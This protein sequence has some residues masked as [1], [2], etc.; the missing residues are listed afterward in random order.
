VGDKGHDFRKSLVAIVD[1]PEDNVNFDCPWGFQWMDGEKPP[2]EKAEAPAPV[3]A[4]VPLEGAPSPQPLQ[5]GKPGGCGCGKRS[6]QGMVTAPD[7]TQSPTTIRLPNPEFMANVPRSQCPDCT[8][9][10]IAQAII[11]LQE[12]IDGHPEHRMLAIGHLAEAVAEIRQLLPDI[13][14]K[15]EDTFHQMM[16]EPE[17]MP[18]LMPFIM[19]ISQKVAEALAAQGPTGV[20]GT[21]VS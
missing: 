1:L 18:D 15:L 14:A 16:K 8:R 19:E 4:A 5:P 10:H 20:Q 11:T 17:F 12:S 7:G 21:S 9:K 6:V 13:A 2:F 3:P